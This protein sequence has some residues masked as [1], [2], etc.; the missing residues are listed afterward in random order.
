MTQEQMSGE[1]E[2]EFPARSFLFLPANRLEW[3]KKVARFKPQA[4]ILDLE[5]AVPP[6]ER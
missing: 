2:T 3:V 1:D 6:P 4:V 5:D